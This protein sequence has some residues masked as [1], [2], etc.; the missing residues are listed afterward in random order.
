ML[1]K[2]L[3][4]FALVGAHWVLYLLIALSV[5][6]VG[7]M[8][9]RAIFFARRRADARQLSAELAQLLAAG[10]VD[11]ARL[12]VA[13]QD[14]MEERALAE[15]RLLFLGTL[16]NNAPFIGL[17]GT[18]LGIIKAFHD[19]SLGDPTKAAASAQVVMSGVSEALVA[20][21]VGL[22]VALP[23]SLLLEPSVPQ[24]RL[25]GELRLE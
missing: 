15:R 20:T 6:S 1:E 14:G 12:L 19:L 22:A 13:A 17:F 21:A 16:G 5:V 23:G 2:S 11:Q 4:A 10:Q 3:L 24:A 8:I 7:I 9:E 18:V 25:E